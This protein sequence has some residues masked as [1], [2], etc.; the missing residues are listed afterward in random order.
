[1]VVMVQ[2]RIFIPFHDCCH[3]SLSGTPRAKRILGY[4][5]GIL[6]LVTPSA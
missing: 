1:M 2:V 5:T 3:G 4:V 6:T